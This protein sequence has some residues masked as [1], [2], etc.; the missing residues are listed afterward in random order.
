MLAHRLSHIYY[1]EPPHYQFLSSRHSVM[2]RDTKNN[3]AEIDLFG[4]Q[5]LKSRIVTQ[6]S[7]EFRTP[8]TSIVGFAALLEEHEHINDDQRAEYAGYIRNEGLRLTKI[9][10][11]LI[12]LDALEQGNANFLFENSELQN[13][14]YCSLK[15]VHGFASG[16]SITISSDLPQ[17]PMMLKCDSE[18]LVQ[19]IYQLLHNAVRFTK[20]GGSILVTLE[21]TDS[22]IKISVQD[23]GSGISE[24]NLPLLFQRFSKLYRPGDE[25]HGTGVGLAL[26]KYIVEHHGGDILVQ[27]QI[28]K[29]ST[30]T[31]QIPQ[32]S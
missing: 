7:H 11:D 32:N 3:S 1:G 2:D 22:H 18:R 8:L 29:G 27:S 31:I 4:I 10:T 13:I 19:A 6:I 25:T 20:P 21:K 26:A 17:I 12:N 15:L 9:V 28:H 24:E 5:R 14:I 30:F 23:T 16:K